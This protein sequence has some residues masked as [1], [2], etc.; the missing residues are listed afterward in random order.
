MITIYVYPKCST[1]KN[2]IKWLIANDIEHE[3][4]NIV[5]ECPTAS[6]LQQLHELTGLSIKKIF[7]TSGNKYKELGLKDKVD[8]LSYEAC[9]DLLASDGMLIKR[10]LA[11]TNKKVTLGFKIPEY[12]EAWLK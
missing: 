7:N 8:D 9:Y 1:C 12:E 3:I 10:P 6:E 11:Y 2:A 5:T 4:K